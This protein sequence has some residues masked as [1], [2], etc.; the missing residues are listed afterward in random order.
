[1]RRKTIAILA[2]AGL[3]AVTV[4]AASSASAADGS[5]TIVER[6]ARALASAPGVAGTSALTPQKVVRLAGQDRYATAVAVSAATWG[7]EITGVVHL[8]S[9]TSPSDALALGASTLSQGPVLLTER[10]ALPKV[11]RDEIARLRPCQVVVVGG[12]AVV[13]EAVVTEASRYADPTGCLLPV[14]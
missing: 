14:E 12:P 11:T 4:G 2:A 6:R 3:A 9:G 5:G 10:D 7:P 13:S 8:A 1:M